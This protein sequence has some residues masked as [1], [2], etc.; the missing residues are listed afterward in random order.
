MKDKLKNDLKKIQSIKLEFHQQYSKTFNLLKTD[1]WF[2]PI[3]NQKL[4]FMTYND[5]QSNISS[6]KND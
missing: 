6:F 5:N 2:D 4:Q 3:I 1:Q